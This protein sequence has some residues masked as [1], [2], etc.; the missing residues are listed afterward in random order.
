[1]TTRLWLNIDHDPIQSRKRPTLRDRQMPRIPKPVAGRVD[2]R[3]GMHLQARC[4]YCREVGNRNG[5]SQVPDADP[6]LSK[7]Y[8]IADPGRQTLRS[9]VD[10]RDTLGLYLPSG[11]T[12]A[13]R[14]QF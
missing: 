14:K 13:S 10:Y 2:V 8:P 7:C 6:L 9:I 11:S 3:V 4:C 1:M 5:M 12:I